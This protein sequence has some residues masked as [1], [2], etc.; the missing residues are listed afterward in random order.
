MSDKVKIGFPPMF[1]DAVVVRVLEAECKESKKENAMIVV[2]LEVVGIPNNTGGVETE[3]TQNGKKYKI[4]GSRIGTQ[5]FTLKEGFPMDQYEDFWKSAHPG[6]E[7]TAPEGD[8]QTIIDTIDLSWLENLAV[9]AMV[10]VENQVE[11]KYITDEEK[12]ALIDEG[13]PGIGD[14]ILDGA[15]NPVTRQT[16]EIVGGFGVNPWLGKFTGELPTI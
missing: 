1:K 10:R 7:F 16:V 13:K 2:K 4:A 6:E 11:R 5:Y 9:L 12:K 8:V 15:G 3:V 14:P